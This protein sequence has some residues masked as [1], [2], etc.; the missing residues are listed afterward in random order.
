SATPRLDRNRRD[1]RSARQRGI[2]AGRAANRARICLAGRRGDEAPE[3]RANRQVWARPRADQSL[4]G[5]PACCEVH[6][7]RAISGLD[8]A[9]QI[10]FPF[11]FFFFLCEALCPSV[12]LWLDRGRIAGS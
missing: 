9:K 11:F 8:P 6:D 5:G 2:L 10:P 3:S 4:L 1:T 12:S 7:S